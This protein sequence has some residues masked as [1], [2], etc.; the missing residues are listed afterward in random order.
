MIT[1]LPLDLVNEILSRLPS[2]TVTRLKIVSK[3]MKLLISS[4]Q[5]VNYRLDQSISTMT[6]RHYVVT[7][8]RLYD[9]HKQYRTV[10]YTADYDSLDNLVELRHPYKNCET[11]VLVLGSCRGLLLLCVDHEHFL[12]YNP[13]TQTHNVLPFVPVIEPGLSGNYFE[14][15][16]GYDSVARDYKCVRIMQRLVGEKDHLLCE[17]MV[18][19]MKSNCW[20]QVGDVPC[21]FRPCFGSTGALLGDVFH[22]VGENLDR[23]YGVIAAFDLRVETF[24]CLPLPSFRFKQDDSLYIG[25]L[26]DC[27]CLSVNNDLL[28]TVWIMKEYGV[29]GSWTR[30]YSIEKADCYHFGRLINYSPVKKRLLVRKALCE[31]GHVD[32]ETM[33]YTNMT[34]NGWDSCLDAD[35]Y[36]E[37]LLTLDYYEFAD[38]VGTK[39]DQQ[40]KT[41]NKKRRKRRNKRT[42]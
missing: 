3:S 16:F 9:R 14:C 31:L 19:S 38:D 8:P 21:Y 23:E 32:L 20:R 24:S 40:V 11:R 37:N 17:V 15:G 26:D 2:K 12:L 29:V 27:L 42:L 5:V 35:V 18:Y 1:N 7:I 10:L 33:D 28:C 22:W 13:T 34:F 36:V 25:T 39:K 30:T 41:K 6:N 4:E